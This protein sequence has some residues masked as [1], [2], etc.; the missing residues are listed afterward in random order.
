MGISKGNFLAIYD[1]PACLCGGPVFGLCHDER[2]RRGCE[3]RLRWLSTAASKIAL[4][5]RPGPS[6]GPGHYKEFEHADT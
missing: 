2:I 1:E 6:L 3:S 4:H 5:N